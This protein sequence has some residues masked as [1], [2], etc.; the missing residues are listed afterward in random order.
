MDF[1]C[2]QDETRTAA[3]RSGC[4]SFTSIL[5][6]TKMSHRNSVRIVLG[7]L[8]GGHKSLA[9]AVLMVGAGPAGAAILFSYDFEPPAVTGS[10]S[11]AGTVLNGQDGWTIAN[12]DV[13]A[14]VRFNV[15]GLDNTNVVCNPASVDGNSNVIGAGDVR[16]QRNIS[17]LSF[18]S[19]DTAV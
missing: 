1:P 5:W 9:L 12:A 14:V 17:P 18:T 10:D 19:A 2:I 15:P 3:N 4:C 13:D 6:E 16:S 8:L 11:L 7:R